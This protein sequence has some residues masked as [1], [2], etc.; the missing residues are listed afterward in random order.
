[1][2]RAVFW[3]GAFPTLESVLEGGADLI[4]RFLRRVGRTD[5]PVACS[6]GD[7]N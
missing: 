2:A 7:G 1:M 5:S 6:E 3:E 4:E